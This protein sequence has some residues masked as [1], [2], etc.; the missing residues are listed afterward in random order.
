M[1]WIHAGS[2][3][4]L[5]GLV[6][7]SGAQAQVVQ[8]PTFRVFGMSTTVSA[9][10]RGSVSL[11]GTSS[12]SI[13]RRERG[14]PGLGCVP[15]AGRPFGNRTT[16]GHMRTSGVSVGAYIHD[17][18]AIDEDLRG[19]ARGLAR[20]SSP[21]TRSPDAAGRMSIAELRRQQ[22]DRQAAVQKEAIQ[23]YE[24]ARRLLA[25]GRT[26]L[27]EFYFERAAKHADPELR[28]RIAATIR[29]Q[30]ADQRV[31]TAD[32]TGPRR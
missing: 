6:L 20:H 18:E 17:L 28:A 2:T 32:R 10:D 15:F 29:T 16:A 7:A 12:S 19:Q 5:I 1:R 3:V 22:V 14:V 11:G 23:D 9:P 4:M 27:A 30:L 25:E 31:D 24:R 26:G 8:L 13:G 21:A